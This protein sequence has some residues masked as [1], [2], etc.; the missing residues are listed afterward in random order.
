MVLMSVQIKQVH[1]WPSKRKIRFNAV[2]RSLSR[3]ILITVIITSAQSPPGHRGL[4]VCSAVDHVTVSLI[5]GRRMT[6]RQRK[7]IPLQ[8]LCIPVTRPL[9]LTKWWRCSKCFN[10]SG[11]SMVEVLI[12][13]D[14]WIAILLLT[15]TTT[16]II[17]VMVTL[18]V[19]V[20]LLHMTVFVQLLLHLNQ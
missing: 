20:H 15:P 11:V 5:S 1:V 3:S 17:M 18:L 19:L 8:A 16:P 14:H 4:Q 6:T 10:P 2:I 12:H 9:N 13:R 7:L